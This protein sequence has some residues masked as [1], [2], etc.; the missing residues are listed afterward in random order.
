MVLSELLLALPAKE[1]RVQ[2][3]VAFD[4]QD[5]PRDGICALAKPKCSF[6][7]SVLNI[8]MIPDDLDDCLFRVSTIAPNAVDHTISVLSDLGSPTSPVWVPRWNFSTDKSGS[9][10]EGYLDD[11]LANRKETDLIIR[12]SDMVHF[13]GC[14]EVNEIRND[15]TDWFS[16]LGLYTKQD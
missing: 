11:L 5:G 1:W 4:W 8:R 6:Y 9:V 10:V 14:W 12:S 2:Q 3:I 7:F 13:L 15:D 16:V